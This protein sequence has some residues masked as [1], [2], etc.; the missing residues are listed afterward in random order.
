M[1]LDFSGMSRKQVKEV[2]T[3]FNGVGYTL[4][5]TKEKGQYVI[6]KIE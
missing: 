5:A 4:S 1:S 2:G 3:L 6:N